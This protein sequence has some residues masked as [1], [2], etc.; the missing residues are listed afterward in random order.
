MSVA[1]RPAAGGPLTRAAAAG[2]PGPLDERRRRLFW[3]F[4]AP[5]LAL[6]LILFIGPTFAT[7]W[8]SLHKWR[9]SGEMEWRALSNYSLLLQDPAFKTSFKNTLIILVAGGLAVFILSFALT[10]VLRDMRGRKGVRAILFF[11]N[12]VAPLALAVLWGFLFRSDG[13]A[14]TVLTTLG[15]EH[16][17]QWLESDTLFPMILAGLVWIH[18]GLYITILMAA[19]DRIPHHFYEDS[20]LA[21][22]G[23]LQRFRHV[24]LPLCWDV[25]AVAAVLWTISSIKIFDFIYAFAG[26]TGDL[27]PLST[28]NSAI[29]VYGE[30]FG[31]RVA[32]YK[33]GYASASAVVTLALIAIFV[34]LMRRLMRREAV[35]Y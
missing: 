19:V 18:T 7:G 29:F 26:A 12:I 35:E 13:V 17:P 27:P 11:P 25:I 5:A 20:A 8:I 30:T 3:P 24:T 6:Y 21:G 23:A 32:P 34:V 4:V 14:N 9:G 33:F 28:W 1:L 31:G 2:T 16:P 15:W 10:M 22:A